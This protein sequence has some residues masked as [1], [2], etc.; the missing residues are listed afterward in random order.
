M[1]GERADTWHI[2]LKVAGS[3]SGERSGTASTSAPDALSSGRNDF[4][5][6]GPN[7]PSR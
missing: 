5:L 1:L 7:D 6:S 4:L 3:A 2:I